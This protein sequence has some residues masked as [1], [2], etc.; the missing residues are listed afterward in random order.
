ML[1]Q[2][3]TMPAFHLSGLLDAITA[4]P[5]PA[6]LAFLTVCTVVTWRVLAKREAAYQEQVARERMRSAALERARMEAIS[7][8]SA[9]HRKDVA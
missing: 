3:T 6:T 2:I 4:D 7:R 1:D 9:G 8:I 5:L